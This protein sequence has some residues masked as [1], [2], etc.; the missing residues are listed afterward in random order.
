MPLTERQQAY[1]AR[2]RRLTAVLLAIWLVVTFVVSYF[3]RDLS[4]RMFGWPFSIWMAG[5][6]SLLVYLAIIGFYARS[7]RRLDR[8]YGVAEDH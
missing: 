5:Q 4:G 1:W 8:E 2:T 7:M 3:A 6:G